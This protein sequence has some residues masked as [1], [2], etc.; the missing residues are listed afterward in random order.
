MRVGQ[1]TAGGSATLGV[2]VQTAW[3]RLNRHAR[4]DVIVNVW[5]EILIFIGITY[6]LGILH[7][8]KFVNANGWNLRAG[9]WRTKPQNRDRSLVNGQDSMISGS[10]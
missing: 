6:I 8:N 3:Q 2:S 1:G 5:W 4:G 7:P 10:L 9:T